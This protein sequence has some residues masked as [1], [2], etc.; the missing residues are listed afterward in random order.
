MQHLYYSTSISPTIR[1]LIG[2]WF[3]VCF[4]INVPSIWEIFCY[5]F[6]TRIRT[7]FDCQVKNLSQF[8]AIKLG[9][10]MLDCIT[11]VISLACY[12]PY[13]WATSIYCIILH[14]ILTDSIN[15]NNR[16]TRSG[17]VCIYITCRSSWSNL[18]WSK[19]SSKRLVSCK[20][21]TI[22]SNIIVLTHV[23]LSPSRK[24]CL[25]LTCNREICT[26]WPSRTMTIYEECCKRVTPPLRFRSITP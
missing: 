5:V 6:L 12:R 19:S 23:R 2:A 14:L 13:I 24:I 25:I 21:L 10:I 1:V 18:G 8:T 9:G 3:A 4:T 11:F 7:R 26:I 15:R 16:L 17:N 22:G 20:S